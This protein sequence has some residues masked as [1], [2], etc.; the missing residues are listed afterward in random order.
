M[1]REEMVQILNACIWAVDGADLNFIIKKGVNNPKLAK[2]GLQL[3][4]Y[5]K[6]KENHSL[7]SPKEQGSINSP[8]NIN[9]RE[10]QQ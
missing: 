10:V 1:N 9:I 8:V 3:Y 2:M 4:S 7:S 5:L 6:S